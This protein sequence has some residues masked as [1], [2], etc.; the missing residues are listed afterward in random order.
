[1]FRIIASVLVATAVGCSF[2]GSAIAWPDRAVRLIL[3]VPAGSA[4]DFTARL[5]AERL[6]VRWAQPVVVDNR[7][8]ADGVIGVSS[9][10]SGHD[11]HTLLFAISAVATVH[12]V[13]NEKL[14]YDPIRDLV[15]IAAASEIV[16]AMAASDKSGIH[17]LEDMVRIARAAPGKLNWA[18]SP[19]LPPFVI[20]AFA[21]EA[22]LEMESVFYRDLSPALQD[23]GEGR[24]DIFVHALSVLM[25]QA[26][27]GRLRLLAV[28]SRERAAAMPN[29]LSVTELGFP[30]LVME[31]L[32]GFF[33]SR[34]M[35]IAV[36]E[37]VA[38]DVMAV[39]NEPAVQERLAPIGQTVHPGTSAEFAAFLAA[40]RERLMVLARV[41]GIP[42]LHK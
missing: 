9:F 4:A 38:A 20:G 34:E 6:S 22:G 29:L 35:P 36:R 30:Q 2:C 19:G 31:G 26:Q 39:A 16:L 21:K 42:M 13:Q 14:P 11:D 8:G 15:P 40:S 12:V 32:C 24:L 37:Q 25:P 17:S 10:V 7:P 41:S 33:G 27:A 18:S 23:L 3:P 5:F 1:M 28:A